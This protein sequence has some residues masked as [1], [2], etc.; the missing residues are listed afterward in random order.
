MQQV[1]IG[2]RVLH[3]ECWGEPVADEPTVLLISGARLTT[4]SWELMASR[5]AAEDHHLC[6]YDRAGVGGSDFA[7]EPRRT[8]EDQVTDLLALL[9]AADFQEPVVVAAHSL[10]SLPA[11]ELAARAPER[12]AG[13]VLVDPWSPRVSVAQQAALPPEKPHEPPA[14]IEERRFLNEFLTDPSQNSEHIDH[15]AS[16]EAMIRLLDEPGPLLGDL[17]V[18]VLKAPLPPPPPGL[19]DSYDVATRTAMDEGAREFAAESTQGT[20]T[21]VRDTGHN[22]QEDRPGVV[23]DAIREV[24]AG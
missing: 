9:D 22:I 21:L 5:F 1:D 18:V 7:P 20:L 16:D 6:S 2:G 3:V 11:I 13:L 10:G 8:T 4:G 14:L 15:Q 24:M 19:P 23:I 12:V 17:P